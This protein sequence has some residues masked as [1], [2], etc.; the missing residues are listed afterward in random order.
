[1]EY[2]HFY[3]QMIASQLCIFVISISRNK[4]VSNKNKQLTRNFFL[5]AKVIK[6]ELI[7]TISFLLLIIFEFC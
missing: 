5:G 7:Q 3:K 6:T 2:T 1:M 4:I